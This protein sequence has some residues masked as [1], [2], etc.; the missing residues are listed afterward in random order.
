M[1]G[2]ANGIGL[3]AAER[4]SNEGATVLAVDLAHPSGA[5]PAGPGRI[6][7]LDADIADQVAMQ[8]VMDTAVADYGRIDSL[9]HVAGITR[10]AMHWDMELPDF[11][12]VIRVNL[13][14]S[15]I[16]A[17]AA[18]AVM[19]RQGAGSIVL[20]A[21]RIH[22]GNAGQASYT[23]SKGGVVSLT[24]TLALELGASGVRVNAVAP[25]FIE[26]RMTSIHPPEV[27]ERAIRAAPLG[28]TGRPA[29]VAG[30]IRFL[31]SDDSS[32]MT[33]QILYVDGGRSVTTAPA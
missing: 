19:R 33:G 13:T 6:I 4:L 11:E 20:T 25:G 1:T 32:F 8:H 21:S 14:G 28:R 2:A 26:S 22:L 18:S 16:V 3:A 17:R 10:D 5:E 12:E 15:F 27:R 29:D 23:A 31:V 24:R 7:P 9:V 30:V